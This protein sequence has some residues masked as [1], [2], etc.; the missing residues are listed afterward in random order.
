MKPIRKKISLLN[1]WNIVSSAKISEEENAILTK[2][3]KEIRD[4]GFEPISYKI[5][6]ASGWIEDKA[7][8]FI[9]AECKY[10]KPTS[11]KHMAEIHVAYEQKGSKAPKLTN[12]IIVDITYNKRTGEV[13]RKER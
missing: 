7:K 1:H 9:V 13:K 3:A 12:F 11:T 6:E 4:H 10:K 8:Y 2:A 5:E